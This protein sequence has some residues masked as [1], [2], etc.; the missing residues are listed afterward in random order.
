MKTE[1]MFLYSRTPIKAK[2][3]SHKRGVELPKLAQNP[4]GVVQWWQGVKYRNTVP[5]SQIPNISR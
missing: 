2:K 4:Q 3:I 5:G 1:N